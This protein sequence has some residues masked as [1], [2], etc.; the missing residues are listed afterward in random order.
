MRIKRNNFYL[1]LVYIIFLS[2]L[3]LTKN[4]KLF[5][6]FFQGDLLIYSNHYKNNSIPSYYGLTLYMSFKLFNSWL[7]FSYFLLIYLIVFYTTIF[8]CSLKLFDPSSNVKYI[9]FAIILASYPFYTGY[10]AFV[11]KQGLGMIFMLIHIFYVKKQFSILSILIML[12]A[13]FSHYIF[14]LFFIIFYYSKFFNLRVLIFLMLFSIFIYIFN[15]KLFSYQNLA[16][17]LEN[18]FNFIGEDILINTFEGVKIKFAIY[19]LLP[20]LA[21]QVKQFKNTINENI[22]LNKIIKFH[23]LYSALIYIFFSDYY[24]LD[25]FLSLTWIL[26]PFYLIPFFNKVFFKKKILTN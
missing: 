10:A 17:Y 20:L 26:Y 3:F 19:S 18:N 22:I 12:L 15:F 16:L 8:V 25:R 2:V 11:L 24:Y 14:I 4:Q 21:L 7:A 23:F 6:E 5:T 13:I 1:V 9:L